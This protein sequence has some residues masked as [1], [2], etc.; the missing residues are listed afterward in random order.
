[1]MEPY[2]D[3]VLIRRD[4]E[5]LETEGGII[6]PEGMQTT[7]MCEGSVLGVGS[8]DSGLKK[9]MRVAFREFSGIEVE[10]NNETLII[11][12]ESDVFAIFEK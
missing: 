9:G 12:D 3:R 10:H 6:L 11:V 2:G 8:K 5:I 7:K 1:M 4:E